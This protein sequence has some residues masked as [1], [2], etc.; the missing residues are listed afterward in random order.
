M[1]IDEAIEDAEKEFSEKFKNFD[2]LISKEP[3][4]IEKGHYKPYQCFAITVD[5]SCIVSD[6]LVTLIAKDHNPDLPDFIYTIY[7]QCHGMNGIYR[8]I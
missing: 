7:D 1:T 2:G 8:Y 5:G 6:F 3:D 4:E